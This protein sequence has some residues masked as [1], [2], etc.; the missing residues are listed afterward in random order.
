MAE[1]KTGT[2]LGKPTRYWYD[3]AERVGGSFVAAF[4]AV[5]A[6]S[7]Y[8]LTK[9]TIEAAAVAACVTVVKSI[10]GGLKGNTGTASL[11]REVNDPATPPPVPPE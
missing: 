8:E 7:G 1:V 3:M 4:V 5:W 11:L 2:F 10:L 6:V 9:E